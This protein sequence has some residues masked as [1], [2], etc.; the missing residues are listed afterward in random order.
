MCSHK[1]KENDT[2]SELNNTHI[3]GNYGKLIKVS[4]DSVDRNLK[5]W[6]K[7]TNN[8]ALQSRLINCAADTHAGDVQYHYNCYTRLRY[9]AKVAEKPPKENPLEFDPFVIAQLIVYIT[10]VNGVIKVAD[11]KNLYF[12]RL[13]ELGQSHTGSFHNTRF[14]DTLLSHLPSG[15]K[16]YKASGCLY[17][18]DEDTIKDLIK[19]AGNQNGD[20]IQQ[21]EVL[22]LLKATSIL[23]KHS[24][25]T[26]QPFQG[27]F[28]TNCLS[29]PVGTFLFFFIINLLQGSTVTL[30]E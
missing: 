8:F 12:H 29:N 5:N 21:D 23:R 9:D 1:S 16:A 6:A 17:L 15:W 2:P 14:K 27:H 19:K 4:L 28:G 7:A 10:E 3:S 20:K 26:Q 30:T 13:E 18:S 22:L 25:T 24:I 11:L